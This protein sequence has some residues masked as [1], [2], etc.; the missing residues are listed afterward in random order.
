MSGSKRKRRLGTWIIALMGGVAAL[1]IL[2]LALVASN[3]ES[4]QTMKPIHHVE[5]TYRETL[6][7][8]E[9]VQGLQTQL[10]E[11]Y[12]GSPEVCLVKE[13]EQ[14]I[15]QVVMNDPETTKWKDSQ[16]LASQVADDTRDLFRPF[17]DVHHLE[18]MVK[19][20]QSRGRGF[21][22]MAYYLFP[23]KRETHVMRPNHGSLGGGADHS[24]PHAFLIETQT[25]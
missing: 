3:W 2:A 12:G 24:L 17:D 11:L 1:G 18:V 16:A 8:V 10:K 19:V 21:E 25:R 13:G 22:N 5:Q 14:L 7:W 15:L 23:K 20:A 4:I 9:D 6:I